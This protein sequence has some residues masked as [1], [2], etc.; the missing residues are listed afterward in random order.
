MYLRLGTPKSVWGWARQ[1]V[2]EVGHSKEFLG[3]AFSLQ[4]ESGVSGW[5]LLGTPGRLSGLWD[6]ALQ[7]SGL[8]VGHSRSVWAWAL[9]EKN[10]LVSGLGRIWGRWA[11]WGWA[12][13]ECGVGHFR[14]SL[15]LGTPGSL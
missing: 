11:L 8:W 4:G 7:D 10:L 14:E 6:W 15:G 12:L 9:Q 1:G 3:F 13:Q 2:S 5:A